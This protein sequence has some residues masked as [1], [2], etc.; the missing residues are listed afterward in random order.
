[1]KLDFPQFATSITPET[2]LVTV[3]M[4]EHLE[5]DNTSESNAIVRVSQASHLRRHL[6]T[7]C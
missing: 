1:M 4:D 6:K 5:S 2:T 3:E 7:Q